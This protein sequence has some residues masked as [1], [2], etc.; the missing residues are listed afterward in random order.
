VNGKLKKNSEADYPY[1]LT[2]RIN[3]DEGIEETS[4][5]VRTLSENELIYIAPDNFTWYFEKNNQLL[6]LS[7]LRI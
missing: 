1:L 5:K 4:N 7:H 2:L 3:M 6:F